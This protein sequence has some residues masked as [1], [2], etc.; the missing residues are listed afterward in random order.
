MKIAGI[1]EAG[2]G[3]V[4]GPL[5]MAVVMIDEKDIV[6]LENIGVKDSK[7]LSELQRERFFE[8]LTQEC[9]YITYEIVQCSPKEI[10]DALLS[11]NLNLNSFEAMHSAILLG[12]LN[13]R[14]DKAI[15]DLP[16]NNREKYEMAVRKFLI[17]DLNKLVLQSEHKADDKYA[18]VSAASILAK[19]TRDR[20]I[21]K[22]RQKIGIDFGSGYPSDPKTIS[23]LKKNYNNKEFLKLG[24]FRKTW[25]SYRNVAEGKKQKSLSEW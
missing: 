16:S 19:V 1:D 10:D 23:F 22:L 17:D 5:V 6:K 15:L 8:V 12:K 4:I 24:I 3:P 21:M 25:Q 7:Q 14:P 18:V 20:E 2:R 13:P 11:P 9:N